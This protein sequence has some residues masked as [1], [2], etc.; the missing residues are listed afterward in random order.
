MLSTIISYH[1][2]CCPCNYVLVVKY[3]PCLPKV[4]IPEEVLSKSKNDSYNF[5]YNSDSHKPSTNTMCGKETQTSLFFLPLSDV[6][7]EFCITHDSLK[8]MYWVQEIESTRFVAYNIFHVEYAVYITRVLIL[9]Q[10]SA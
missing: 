10:S 3:I 7:C 8:L 4:T 2:S 1:T 5:T 9:W 6:E